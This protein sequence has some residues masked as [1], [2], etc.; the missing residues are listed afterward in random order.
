[1][2]SQADP[3]IALEGCRLV[4]AGGGTGGHLFPGIAIA[5]EFMSRHPDNRVLFVNAGRSLETKVLSDLGWSQQ[6]ISIEGIKGRGWW[7][8]M[9]AALKIPKA[10]WQSGSILKA[11]QADLVF[12]VGGYSAGPVVASAAFRGIPTALHEQ[13]RVPGVTNRI[14][15]RM[16]DQIYLT[17]EES[18]DLFNP[19]KVTVS[20]NP[21][22]G[23]LL[24]LALKPVTAN[25]KELFALLVVGGSQGAQA[26]NAAMLEALPRL[27]QMGSIRIVHQ[28]GTGDEEKVRSAYQQNTIESDVRAFF[29]D[30]AKQY[31]AA[32]MI[33]CR[34]GATTVAEITAIGK[35]AV[36]VPFPYATD[37]HQTENARALVDFGAAEMIQEDELSGTKLADLIEGYKEN[38]VLLRDMAA[39]AKVLGR[40]LAAQT[41][42]DG[43]Y[44]MLV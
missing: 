28:T 36:F 32:D 1:M 31:Q 29:T 24:D 4:M 5:E 18:K 33:I 17:F 25:H 19:E 20:G 37:D 3:E 27:G 10:L 44:T 43:L 34:A 21:V 6:A 39:K 8:K 35:A 13:N 26:I 14:L 9:S 30:M 2:Q 41:V 12:G 15:G 7:S 23:Q 40:P 16:V 11:F 38:R 22:R 42:V